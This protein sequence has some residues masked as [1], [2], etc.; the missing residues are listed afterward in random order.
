MLRLVPDSSSE[1]LCK[2]I[3][4]LRDSF[5]SRPRLQSAGP[6]RVVLANTRLSCRRAPC[7]LGF[8]TILFGARGEVHLYARV[9]LPAEL[10]PMH[11]ILSPIIRHM[12][13]Q[14]RA[15]KSI[16]RGFSRESRTGSCRRIMQNRWFRCARSIV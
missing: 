7:T 8:N 9:G 3:V 16:H 13:A 14:K 6:R 2:L 1:L 12:R 10:T 5:L 4:L 11:E 15:R